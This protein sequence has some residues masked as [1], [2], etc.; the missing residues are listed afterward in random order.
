MQVIACDPYVD[1]AH[2]KRLGV[3]RVT[4]ED[5]AARA[6]YVSVHRLLN[7][8][9]RHLIN[10]AFLRVVYDFLREFVFAPQ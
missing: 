5:L 3:E 8:S 9:T 7:A 10:A 2:F 1:E 4:L 6:D